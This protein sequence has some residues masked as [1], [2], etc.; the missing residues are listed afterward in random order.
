M[1]KTQFLPAL[2][3]IT[4]MIAAPNA[5][6]LKLEKLWVIDQGL[7]GPETVTYDPKRNIAYVS[8]YNWRTPI[9]EPA[10]DY[11]SII[12]LDGKLIKEK[13]IEGL[14][15]P[16]GM[17][18]YK[19]QLYVVERWGVRVIDLSSAKTVKEYKIDN[20]TFLNDLSID[21]KGTVYVS[22]SETGIVHRI[23]NGKVEAWRQDPEIAKVNGLLAE[24]DSLLLAMTSDHTLKRLDLKTGRY[25]TLTNFGDGIVDGIQKYK[26]GYFVSLYRGELFYVNKS[27]KELVLNTSDDKLQ[28]AN[29]LF[30]E[31][32]KLFILPSLRADL[33]TAYRLVE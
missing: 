29:F 32:Q 27:Q 3:A 23:K 22:D 5:M 6:A 31:D 16:L 26:G 14:S 24:D 4:V 30:I 21:K 7:E 19:D 1:S 20:T 8:N 15:S 9:E 18:I 33:L 12:S 25:T 13:W 11:L 28:I 17:E 2:I 10:T